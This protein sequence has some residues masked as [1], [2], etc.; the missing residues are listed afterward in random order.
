MTDYKKTLHQLQR[1]VLE[2][3]RDG[4][5]PA[6]HAADLL[7][8]LQKLDGASLP[9]EREDVAIIG[10]ACKLPDATNLQQFGQNLYGG[11]NSVKRLPEKRSEPLQ[12]LSP[13]MAEALRDSAYQAG[14]LADIFGFD[15]GFFRISP[16]EAVHMDPLQRLMLGTAYQAA[17]D[18]G[19]GGEQLRGSRTGIF[20]G[21]DTS[22]KAVYRELLDEDNFLSLT[23]SLTGIIASR[24]AYFLHLRGPAVVVDSACSSSLAALHQACLALRN[25]DCDM[26]LVGGVNLFVRPQTKAGPSEIES[27]HPALRAF[28]RESSGTLWGE[29]AVAVCLKP[30]SKAIADG[31]PVYAVIKGSAINNDGASNGITAPSRSAQTEVLTEAWERAGIPPE[32]IA[33]IETHGTGTKLGDPVEIQGIAEAFAKYTSNKQFCGIGSVKSNVG[34]TVAASGLTS[35]LK[36]VLIV[37]HKMIPPSLHFTAPNPL[38]AF[39][40]SPVYFVNRLEPIAAQEHPVRVG[41]SSFGFS[42]TN[43]HLVL[44]EYRKPTSPEQTSATDSVIFTLSAK[45]ERSLQRMADVCARYIRQHPELD[46]ADASYTLQMGRGHYSHR[47]AVLADHRKSLLAALESFVAG[48]DYHAVP[49][50]Y[51]GVHKAAYRHNQDEGSGRPGPMAHASS[52][53]AATLEER[54]DETAV[55]AGLCRDYV[56]GADPNWK[57][58]HAER[59]KRRVHLPGYSF[60]EA[61]YIPAAKPLPLG[62]SAP[63][64]LPSMLECRLLSETA[65]QDVYDTWFST[66]AHWVLNEHR[67]VGTPTVPGVTYLEIARRIGQ[68]YYPEQPLELKD[69]VFMKPFSLAEHQQGNVRTVVRKTGTNRRSFSIMSRRTG[70]SPALDKEEWTTHVEGVMTSTAEENRPQPLDIALLK[71]RMKRLPRLSASEHTGQLQMQSTAVFE[72]GAR[73]NNLQDSYADD[74]EALLSFRLPEQYAGDLH[75]CWLHPALLDNA[76]NWVSFHLVEG[77]YLPFSYESFQ[78]FGPM[79]PVFYT[80]VQLDRHAS[81][82]PSSREVYT[83]QFLLADEEGSVFARADNYSIKRVHQIDSVLTVSGRAQ[84][85]PSFL[86]MGRREETLSVDSGQK[87]TRPLL[88]IRGQDDFFGGF[89]PLLKSAGHPVVEA[90]R[91]LLEASQYAEAVD[92]NFPFIQAIR[93]QDLR[94]IVLAAPYHEWADDLDSDKSW[95]HHSSGLLQLAALVRG[96]VSAGISHQVDITVVMRS[97]SSVNPDRV[98]FSPSNAG[99]LAMSQVINQEYEHLRCRCIELNEGTPIDRLLTELRTESPWL[100]VHY[101]EHIRYVPELQAVDLS[102]CAELPHVIREEGVY[103]ITGGTGGLGL[104]TARYLASKGRVRLA[105]VQRSPFPDPT[106]W[107]ALLNEEVDERTASKLHICLEIIQSGSQIRC[108]AADVGKEESLREALARIR[109]DYGNIDG[110]FHTAGVAGTGMLFRKD[111]RQMMDV[112]HPKLQGAI[113]LDRLTTDDDPELMVLYS[114]TSAF[115]GGIGQADYAAANRMLDAYAAYRSSQGKRTLSISWTAWRATGMAA[116]YGVDEDN[117]MFQSITVQEAIHALDQ[118]LH[119]QLDQIIVGPF[120]LSQEQARDVDQTMFRLSPELRASLRPKDVNEA[121]QGLIGKGADTHTTRHVELIDAAAGTLGETEQTLATIW[122]QVLGLNKVHAEDNFYEL[123]GDSIQAIQIVKQIKEHYSC[124]LP[125]TDVFLYPTIRR[126]A[127]RLGETLVHLET[128]EAAADTDELEQLLELVGDQQLSIDEGVTLF[129]QK[130]RKEQL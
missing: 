102:S 42:G 114:S 115:L 29:G 3:V 41:V 35:L 4:D 44:E 120:H 123:G 124:D 39:Q 14:Y 51:Y 26:A 122:G 91:S 13:D 8:E 85:R 17:E 18:A 116:D 129:L 119:R 16:N 54:M 32:T 45:N 63:A 70:Q 23:G 97:V 128:A 92:T 11:T 57:L 52:Q 48:A 106:Q 83:I 37:Q 20:I 12:Q 127:Q 68:R 81:S 50:L 62:T 111:N 66:Q 22:E 104:E 5:I 88:L 103:V 58:L 99:L 107:Q 27:F 10:T 112:I 89:V 36:S 94:H 101:K 24:L 96:L 100:S 1:S 43:V 86:R 65:E 53:S 109:E 118:A 25:K 73:W 49:H 76:A 130:G 6:E 15:P 28:D 38:I 56:Q 19:Y 90:D 55:L 121:D 21:L 95:P 72:W 77:A 78:I 9:A 110:I 7:T 84:V 117:E 64:A 74:Q 82:E 113:L 71:G 69:I 87:L 59:G 46:L 126:F 33:Y 2:L 79:P 108:Y 93:E 61:V 47:L 40:D 30:L 125:I 80:Y 105:L 34:H 67:I 31:D 60:D 98:S 75:D